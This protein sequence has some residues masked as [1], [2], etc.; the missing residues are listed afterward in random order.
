MVL[1]DEKRTHIDL[2][3]ESGLS[4]RAYSIE[5]KLAYKTF[6]NWVK[7]Y[8]PTFV[9]GLKKSKKTPTPFIPIEVSN[10]IDLV[11][12]EHT[13]IEIS[14]PSGVRMSCPTSMNLSQLKA[15]IKL[16]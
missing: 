14:Y 10:P 8:D 12:S 13:S 9:A 11:S 6:S 1:E 16:Y 4:K 15:L 7:K 5:A 3:K 2:W